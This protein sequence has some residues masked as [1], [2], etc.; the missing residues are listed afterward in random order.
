MD[1]AG[2]F[3]FPLISLAQQQSDDSSQELVTAAPAMAYNVGGHTRVR[4]LHP[5]AVFDNLLVIALHYDFSRV[6]Y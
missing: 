3:D 1:S 6:I 2:E 4:Q 5:L